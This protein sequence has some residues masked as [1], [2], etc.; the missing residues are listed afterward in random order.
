MRH[1]LNSEIEID[2]PPNKVW[3][4]LTD[5]DAYG[6]WNPFVTSATGTVAA[7]ERLLN[8]MEPPGGR[9]MTFK[10]VVTEVTEGE[11][12]EWTGRLGVPGLFDG[13]HRFELHETGSGTRLVQDEYFTGIL[14]RLLR[15]D[16]DDKTIRGFRAMN[17]ALKQRCEAP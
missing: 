6:H 14:V 4:V 8:R 15:K 13:R 11:V 9:A 7:G 1:E 10:P 16:L 17:E 12:F 5:L 3:E 2:A